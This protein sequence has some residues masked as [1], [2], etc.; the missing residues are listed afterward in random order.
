[1]RR[2]QHAACAACGMCSMR[3]VQHAAC[4]ACGLCS[5]RRVQHAACA[6]CGVC[7]MWRVQCAPGFPGGAFPR[8]S[9]CPAAK[10]YQ[11][12]WATRLETHASCGI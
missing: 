2:V 1:M 6:A 8:F 12:F 7:S 10:P 9:G 11:R 3:R 5:M 4:A